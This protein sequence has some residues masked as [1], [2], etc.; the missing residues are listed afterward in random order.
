[1]SYSTYEVGSIIDAG[2]ELIVRQCSECNIVYA[3]PNSLR[4]KCITHGG[5][6]HCPNGHNQC[7][8]GKT[9]EEQLAEERRRSGRLAAERDQI[10]ASRRAQKGAT[11]RAKKR[12][13]AG[14]CPACKRTFQNVQRHM[15]S[16]HPQYD[17]SQ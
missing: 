5:G 12:H 3:V 17:P 16:Q 11:T 15:E 1:M 6:W 8:I 13:A 14:V 4:E 9:V 7:P 10:E 2:T